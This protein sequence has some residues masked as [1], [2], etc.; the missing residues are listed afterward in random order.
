MSLGPGNMP[1]IDVDV[2]QTW[3]CGC[4][5]IWS[6]VWSVLRATFGLPVSPLS[7]IWHCHL[8]AS[9]HTCTYDI[10]SIVSKFHGSVT[11]D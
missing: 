4:I 2:H 7:V 3:G 11:L 1:R 10:L 5:M 9:R 6:H 8:S